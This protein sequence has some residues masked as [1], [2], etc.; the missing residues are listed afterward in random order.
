MDTDP[1][2]LQVVTSLTNEMEATVIV[3]ALAD[4]GI[5]AEAVG[6]FTAGFKAEAPGEVSVVVGQADAARAR[7]AL[8]EIRREFSEIDWSMVDYSGDQPPSDRQDPPAGKDTEADD[9]CHREGSEREHRPFQFG[10]ASLL[11]LQAAVSIVLA[12]WK[13]LEAG[14]SGM[15]VLFGIVLATPILI[16]VAG[17]VSIASDL[18]RARARWGR[19]VRLLAVGFVV[20]GL[21][22]LILRVLEVLGITL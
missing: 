13:G 14:P 12:V 22:V 15:L 2:S 6:G 5:R 21:P 18:N 3:N 16:I 9:A 7:K 8:A 10:I 4:H 11:A 19:A 20:I 17:T 1:I